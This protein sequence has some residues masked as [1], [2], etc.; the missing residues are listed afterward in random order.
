MNRKYK[1]RT[2]SVNKQV[3]TNYIRPQESQNKFQNTIRNDKV[4]DEELRQKIRKEYEYANP[5]AS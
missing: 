3:L 4:I 1:Q 5:E 2:A